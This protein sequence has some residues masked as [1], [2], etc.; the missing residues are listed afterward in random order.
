M[1]SYM[2]DGQV[3]QCYEAGADVVIR[4]PS[5][6]ALLKITVKSICDFWLERDD[7]DNDVTSS[8]H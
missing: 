2:S 5:D 3:R 1:S 7:D 8:A 6:F 4:K